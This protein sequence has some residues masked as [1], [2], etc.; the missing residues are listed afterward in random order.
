[1]TA[2]DEGEGA[3][4]DEVAGEEDEVG[5]ES[6]Y[7]LND[8]LKEEGLGVLIEVD[9]AE[10]DDAIA[11]EGRWEI[12]DGDG[13]LDDVQFMTGEFAGVESQPC[14]G[15]ACAYD[16]VSPGESGG[17][18]WGNNGHIAMITGLKTGNRQGNR[19]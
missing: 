3:V 1:M 6:I 13:A 15:D 5:G 11:M 2:G 12:V 18:R 17:L 16:E 7:L 10:L 19:R 14:G 8:A 9:I 4:R